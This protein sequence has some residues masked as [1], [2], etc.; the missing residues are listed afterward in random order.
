[1]RCKDYSVT[2]VRIDRHRVGIVGLADALAAVVGCGLESRKAIEDRL[3]QLLARRNYIPEGQAGSYR[4]ALW[5]E[6]LRHQGLDISDLFDEVEVRVRGPEGDARDRVVDLLTSVLAEF[7]L[8]PL[9]SYSAEL[10]DGAA[11]Q[12]ELAGRTFMR[13]VP[14]RR[15]LR[16]AVYQTFSDW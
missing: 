2:Q 12:L 7:E 16:S 6:Y 13:G 10:G 3:L 15:A 9:I 11:P 1:M 8:R 4:R 5:R 14:T